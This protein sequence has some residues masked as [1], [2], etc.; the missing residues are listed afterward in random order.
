MVNPSPYNRKAIGDYAETEAQHYLEKNGL[1]LLAKNYCVKGGEID[2]VMQDSAYIVF[3]E[4]KYRQSDAYGDAIALVPAYKQQRLIRAATLF[5]LE[6]NIYQ[7]ASGRFD[8]IGIFEDKKERI[9]WIKN[10]FEVQY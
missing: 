5:L 3:V 9:T 6:H 7:T 2:L 8:I 4:V 1:S 10:A